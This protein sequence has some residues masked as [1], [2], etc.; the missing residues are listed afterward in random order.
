M[1]DVLGITPLN[2]TRGQC[3]EL[4]NQLRTELNQTEI[5]ER[6]WQCNKGGSAACQEAYAQ[7]KEI[8]QQ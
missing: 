1:N 7:F 4:I 2:L 5:I 8:T 6:L 3:Y